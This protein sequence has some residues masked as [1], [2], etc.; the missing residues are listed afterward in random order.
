MHV[1][2]NIVVTFWPISIS[3]NLFRTEPINFNATT[4]PKLPKI[5]N[6]LVNVV[7]IITTHS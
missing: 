7:V 3:E 6:V 4:T 2:T 1:V 5:D